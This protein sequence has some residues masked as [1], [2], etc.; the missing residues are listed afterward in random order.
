M[1]GIPPCGCVPS[2]HA[3]EIRIRNFEGWTLKKKTTSGLH[4]RFVLKGMSK[5]YESLKVL[6]NPLANMFRHKTLVVGAT[7]RDAWNVVRSK[8]S[9]FT[10]NTLTLK[11]QPRTLSERRRKQLFNWSRCLQKCWLCDWPPRSPDLSVCEFLIFLLKHLNT[12]KPEPFPIS[13]YESPKKSI[14]YAGQWFSKIDL[15]S[16]FSEIN[17]I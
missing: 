9:R 8:T 1:T 6:V 14:N 3:I 17:G 2:A 16:V 15:P 5:T 11:T 10:K 12:T 4:A 7:R 13:K